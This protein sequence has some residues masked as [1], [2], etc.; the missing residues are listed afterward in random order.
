MNHRPYPNRDDAN[1]AARENEIE[2]DRREHVAR[3]AD[4][5]AAGSLPSDTP[6]TDKAAFL[7][8]GEDMLVVV[9]ADFAR[10]LERELATEKAMNLRNCEDWAS[11]HTYLQKLC[12]EAGFTEHD[13]EGDKYGIRAITQLAD[14]LHSKAAVLGIEKASLAAEMLNLEREN[15]RLELAASCN[16]EELR[17]V[18]AE[19]AR[20]QMHLAGANNAKEENP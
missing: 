1:R 16:A 20:L 8:S 7:E 5:P 13:V 17:Q 11:D 18:R 3:C 14:L 2:Q 10:E 6:R 12:R 19:N 4:T 9:T 15:A